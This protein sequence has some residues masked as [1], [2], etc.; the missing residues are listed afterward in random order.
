MLFVLKLFYCLL[1]IEV[2]FNFINSET[3]PGKYIHFLILFVY[4]I[5]NLIILDITV[6]FYTCKNVIYCKMQ[7]IIR[8]ISYS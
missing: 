5:F 3:I 1:F 2:F 4:T 6:L 7:P 8:R